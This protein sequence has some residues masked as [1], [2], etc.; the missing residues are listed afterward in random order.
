MINLV[1]NIKILCQGAEISISK[2]EK[3]LGFGNATIYN[4]DKSSPSLDKIQKVARYFNKSIDVIFYGFEHSKFID[5]VNMIRSGMSYEKFSEYTRINLED[6]IDICEGRILT[7]PSID[8]I[9]KIDS[10][11]YSL[12]DTRLFEL[13]GYDIDEKKSNHKSKRDYL[14]EIA[15]K[16]LDIGY[17]IIFYTESK[18]NIYVEFYTLAEKLIGRVCLRD[19]RQLTKDLLIKNTPSNPNNEDWDECEYELI[20]V[21]KIFLKISRKMEKGTS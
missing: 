16:F 5:A 18:D 10:R 7:P 1:D 19:F 12:E 13:A 4:W 6:I 8:I 9:E 11:D 20:R 14:T 21:Y 15:N 17:K 2:L 3:E